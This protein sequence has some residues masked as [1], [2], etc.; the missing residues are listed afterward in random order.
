MILNTSER[1]G[2]CRSKIY[3]DPNIKTGVMQR[4]L[5]RV[6]GRILCIYT[7]AEKMSF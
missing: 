4:I 3:F 5:P 7:L 1:Q 6:K 2:F